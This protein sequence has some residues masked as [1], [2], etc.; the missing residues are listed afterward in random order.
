M[1]WL[2][3]QGSLRPRQG[4]VYWREWR[5]QTAL[6]SNQSGH[7]MIRR[8]IFG[9]FNQ[10]H[11]ET[12]SRREKKTNRSF[13]VF[14]PFS[15]AIQIECPQ[16]TRWPITAFFLLFRCR[17][18]CCF[19]FS[20]SQLLTSANQCFYLSSS[21]VRISVYLMSASAP[22]TTL[23]FLFAVNTPPSSNRNQIILK[24]VF[25]H[26]LA[27]PTKH[28]P[29]QTTK[30]NRNLTHEKSKTETK[31]S[32]SNNSENRDL[33]RYS[34]S[35]TVDGKWWWKDYIAS[36][37]RSSLMS[38]VFANERKCKTIEWMGDR[39]VASNAAILAIFCIVFLCHLSW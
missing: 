36:L 24:S 16:A 26:A 5:E 31:K 34:V 10:S 29:N 27:C 6:F 2:K 28:R 32:N 38:S 33:S 35:L 39:V 20:L 25:L 21:F 37:Q 3:K 15:F 11:D 13:H 7:G 30:R 17:S 12:K 8:R 23:G 1:L 9:A 18:R 4:K 22:P 19:L 14:N